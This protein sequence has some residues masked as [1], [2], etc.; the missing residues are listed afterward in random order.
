MIDCHIHLEKGPYTKEW[1]DEFIN[2]AIKMNLDKIQVLEHTHVFKEFQSLYNE[3][4]NYNDYQKHWFENKIVQARPLKDYIEFI[5]DMRNLKFPLQV[6]FGLEVC[7]SPEHYKE[8]CQIRSMIPVDFLVGSIHWIDGWAFSHLKQRWNKEN[9]NVLQIYNR[10][11]D[12]MEDLI[13]S[14]LFDGLAH[15]CSLQCFGVTVPDELKYRYEK[16]AYLLKENDMYVEESSGLVLN[17]DSSLLGMNE[18]ML[19]QMIR[20]NV[21]ILTGSDAHIPLKVGGYISSMEER[22]NNLISRLNSKT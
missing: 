12:L 3:M 8:I 10:Y 18:E 15:P 17:Y 2:Q 14:K 1:L 9:I 13:K 22:I 4:S 19:K 6:K 20:H 21:T 5:K 7:Y 11:F 16:I